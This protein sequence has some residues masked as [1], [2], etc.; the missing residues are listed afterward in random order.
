MVDP[1]EWVGELISRL[2]QEGE[3]RGLP[4]WA[5]AAVCAELDHR[6]RQSRGDIYHYT[7]ELEEGGEAVRVIRLEERT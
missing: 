4:R 3:V 5:H 1:K 7:A 6:A 2:M